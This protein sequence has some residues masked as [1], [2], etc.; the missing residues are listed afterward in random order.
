LNAA[1]LTIRALRATA[2]EVPMKDVLG[3]SRAA[4]RAAP[5]LLIDL[6]TGEGVTRTT[7][8]LLC[9]DLSKAVIVGFARNS[10]RQPERRRWG[11]RKKWASVVADC[12]RQLTAAAVGCAQKMGGGGAGDMAGSLYL[13]GGGGARA[14]RERVPRR[15]GHLSLTS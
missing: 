8:P 14:F 9:S 10:P 13:N 3:T 11:A 6:E 1:K 2:I 12:S 4:I 7:T 5:L 15:A